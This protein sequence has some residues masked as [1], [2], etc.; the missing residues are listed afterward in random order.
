MAR[1]SRQI[2]EQKLAEAR[3]AMRAAMIA[4]YASIAATGI[5]VS[6]DAVNKYLERE[7]AR[8]EQ[9]LEREEQA[10]QEARDARKQQCE[11]AFRMMDKPG[12]PSELR[13]KA[14]QIAAQ[15][16]DEPHD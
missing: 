13:D 6:G 5:G 2:L 1:S 10:A 8:Q 14:E 3:S 12:G 9:V 7:A 11:W 4:A 15:C 16:L